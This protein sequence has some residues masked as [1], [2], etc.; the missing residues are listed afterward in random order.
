MSAP[1]WVDSHCPLGY[2]GTD[3]DPEAAIADARAAGVEALVCVGTDLASSRRAVELAQRHPEVR[4]TVGLHP[5]DASHL[6]EES[7]WHLLD[8][9]G[10]PVIAS[11]SNCRKIV[12]TDRQLSDD[13]IRAIAARG[14][15]IGINFYDKFLVPPSEYGTDG[16]ASSK[17]G[18]V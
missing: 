11:H 8:L 3:E 6:A 18:P 4:A 2:E 12:P 17:I 16:C 1:V 10:G 9:S 5:H 13:M 15:V 14:G 7:F